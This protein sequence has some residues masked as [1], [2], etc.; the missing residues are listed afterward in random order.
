V[1]LLEAAALWVKQQPH[2][3]RLLL[4]S[5]PPSAPSSASEQQQPTGHSTSSSNS[6][7]SRGSAPLEAILAAAA[8]QLLLFTGGQLVRVLQAL[9]G[10]GVAPAR[11]LRQQL[12]AR[13]QGRLSVLKPDELVQVGASFTHVGRGCEQQQL[14]R[15][16]LRRHGW[17]CHQHHACAVAMCLSST[18][19]CCTTASRQHHPASIR[20][21]LLQLHP[22]LT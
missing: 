18:H 13:L 10:C 11:H 8:G 9:L 4:L 20:P 12:L 15:L 19:S 16:L 3:Q 21:T 14:K 6:G 2:N 17:R 5:G 7:D 22:A 1:T